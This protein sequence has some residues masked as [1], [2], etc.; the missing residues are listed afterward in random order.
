MK[1]VLSLDVGFTPLQGEPWWRRVLR[2]DDYP[3][4][5]TLVARGFDDETA[6]ETAA[7]A[8]ALVESLR[9]HVDAA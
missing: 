9:P 8:I 7:R 1:N 6:R 2:E 3:E 5:A 4:Q